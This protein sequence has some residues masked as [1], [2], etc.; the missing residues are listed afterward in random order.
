MIHSITV[1]NYQGESIKMELGKPEASGFASMPLM[2]WD[3]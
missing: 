3:R 2:G 1:T